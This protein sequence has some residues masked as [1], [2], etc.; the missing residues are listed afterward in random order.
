MAINVHKLNK[1]VGFKWHCRPKKVL[2]RKILVDTN[3]NE[4]LL[5]CQIVDVSIQAVVVLVEVDIRL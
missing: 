2:L 3:T 5:C 1:N 4:Q